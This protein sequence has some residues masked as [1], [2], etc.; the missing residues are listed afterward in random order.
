MANSLSCFLSLLLLALMGCQ[1][2]GEEL[3]RKSFSQEEKQALAKTLID[4]IFVYY[5]GSPPRQFLL[6]E[7]ERLF[8]ENADVYRE[9]AAPLVKRGLAADWYAQ[10]EQAVAFDPEGWQG[11]RG[12]L[13]LYFYRDYERALHDFNVID[14]LT[15]NFVD[16][17]QSQSVHFM[18]GICYLQMGDYDQALAFFDRH[19]QHETQEVGLDYIDSRA[20]L[21]KAIT[22][23]KAGSPEQA[24]QTIRMALDIDE[25]NADLWYWLARYE[26]EHG[27]ATQVEP[28][29]ARAR[30]HF[31]E[32]YYHHRPYVEEFYQTY[33]SDLG[34][35]TRD[36]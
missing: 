32:G 12:Y 4:G 11:W 31:D 26:G 6:R 30:Q 36:D 2:P 29:L 35:L 28:C 13:Y 3:Y 23:W 16:Y 34:R 1:A 19:I 22:Q 17:P 33:R 25:R 14:S 21:F 15:P 18:R 9:F 24:A 7:S 20:F 10:Y 27:D 8:P 5:Q